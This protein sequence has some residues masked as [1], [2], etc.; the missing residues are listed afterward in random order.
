MKRLI[1]HA[2]TEYI[3][4][5]L[6]RPGKYQTAALCY[7]ETSGAR[8]VLLISS[9]GTGRWVIPKGNLMRG[10]SAAEAAATEA[11]EEAGVRPRSAPQPVIGE[12]S[13]LKKK[14]SGLPVKTTVLVFPLEVAGLEDTFPEAGQRRR[15]WVSPQEAATMVA[16]PEL[17]DILRDF[18]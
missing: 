13:Y 14:R 16:E 7:R 6:S 15:V 2:L 5:M 17:Q 1:L 8:E 12:F 3:R 18:A 9:R 11:W 4:P 10:L